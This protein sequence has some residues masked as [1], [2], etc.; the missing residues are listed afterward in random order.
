M[1]I[2]FNSACNIAIRP[3]DSEIRV[4]YLET[5]KAFIEAFLHDFSKKNHV[6]VSLKAIQ[7]KSEIRELKKN[8]DIFIGDLDDSLELG[9]NKILIARSP[10]TAITHKDNPINEISSSVLKERFTEYFKSDESISVYAFLQNPDSKSIKDVIEKKKEIALINWSASNDTV[11]ILNIDQN[12][13]NLKSIKFGYYPLKR[14]IYLYRLNYSPNKKLNL[15]INKL[16]KHISSISTQELIENFKLSP[17]SKAEL[18]ILDQYQDSMKIGLALPFSSD[19]IDLAESVLESVKLARDDFDFMNIELIVCDDYSKIP[20]ALDCANLFINKKVK[21]VIGHF[22]SETS[23]ATSRLYARNKIIQISPCSTHPWLT[24]QND[25]QGNVFRA[26]SIDIIQAQIIASL[27]HKLN[28]DLKFK[29]ILLIDNNS[30]FSSN[31]SALIEA[32]ISKSPVKFS[33][34]QQSLIKKNSNIDLIPKE[35]QPDL[36]IFVGGYIDAAKILSDSYFKKNKKTVFIGSD[37]TYSD[38]LLRLAHSKSNGAYIIGANINPESKEFQE[39]SKKL[40]QKYKS[41]VSADGIYGY[42]AASILFSAIFAHE[43]GEY[44]SISEALQKMTFKS[45]GREIRFDEHGDPIE[46]T[47]AI[48]RIENADF[49][50]IN[51]LSSI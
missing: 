8:F 16:F 33:F 3:Q 6:K 41:E 32:E 26:I 9:K 39:Y 44:P 37:G 1:L 20:K 2:I 51:I 5:D 22:N 35:F 38:T 47:Y 42:D 46:S 49:R 13:I 21:A 43:R 4:A 50:K 19:D 11:K 17:L 10:I 18:E 31:L 23:I 25:V 48:Y 34:K 28:Q 15:S 12:P 40:K 36:I 30:L 24:Y 45:L 14:N 27:V 29:K 7:E